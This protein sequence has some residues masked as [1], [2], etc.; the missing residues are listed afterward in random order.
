LSR[1]IRERRSTSTDKGEESD[2]SLLEE[3]KAARG[4]IDGFEDRLNGLRKYGFS[5]ITALLATESLLIPTGTIITSLQNTVKAAV[6]AVTVILI[7]ALHLIDHIYQVSE[8][9]AATRASLI[10]RTLNL[11][12]TDF[13]KSKYEHGHLQLY[14]SC[15]YGAF[16]AGVF[17]LGWA[18]LYPDYILILVLGIFAYVALGVTFQSKPEYDYGI[19]DWTI[20]RLTCKAGDQVGI[21]LT[22][23]ADPGS[24]RAWY[25]KGTIMWAIT[26][27]D[28]QI[29]T[30][31]DLNNEIN[32]KVDQDFPIDAQD[33]YTWLWKVPDDIEGGIYRV[34]P[35]NV[36]PKISR[37]PP[38][39]PIKEKRFPL[40]P[41]A[42]K[43]RVIG[44]ESAESPD[45]LRKAQPVA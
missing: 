43:L 22:S 14:V 41:L 21:T 18:I 26:K 23:L 13:M 27:Q 30:K 15:V 10:E 8:D 7:V 5:F 31:D 36:K 42:A 28:K 11:K 24:A 6:L 39:E 40:M 12:L 20:D 17:I 37:K 9:A 2:S 38:E 16:I 29:K 25:P 33:S 19:V 3:W 34:Y 44:K 45:Q 32:F 1:W 35:T 4:V